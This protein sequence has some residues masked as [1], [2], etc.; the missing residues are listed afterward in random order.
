MGKTNGLSRWPDW[1]VGVEN[2]NDNQIFIKDNWIHRLEEVV[3]ERPEVEI[4]EK[5]KRTRGK[6]EEVVRVIEEMKK[7]KVK[8]L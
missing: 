1:K 7:A 4:L 2:G 6:D 8:V 3:I 5:I